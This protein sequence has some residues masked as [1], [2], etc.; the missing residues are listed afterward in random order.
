MYMIIILSKVI[1]EL[2]SLAFSD[3]AQAAANPIITTAPA[4]T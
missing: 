4:E 1:Q 2:H 3:K